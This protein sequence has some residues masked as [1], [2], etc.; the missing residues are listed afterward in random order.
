[1]VGVSL[2]S[3]PQLNGQKKLKIAAQ[4]NESVENIG[5]RRLQTVLERLLDEISFEAPEKKGETI[6][7]TADYVHERVSGLAADADLS[8]FIL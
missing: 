3:V 5:A 2:Q 4:V 8:K 1:M 7:I 6:T